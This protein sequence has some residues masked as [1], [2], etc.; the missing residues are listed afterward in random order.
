MKFYKTI[1]YFAFITILAISSCKKDFWGRTYVK[2]NNSIISQNSFKYRVNHLELE[3]SSSVFDK[4][5][6][7]EGKKVIGET[8]VILVHIDVCNLDEKTL[9]YMKTELELEKSE[10]KDC[11][12]RFTIPY[13]DI[14]Y[15]NSKE[16]FFEA[17]HC[18]ETFKLCLK[19]NVKSRSFEMALTFEN[20]L[21]V[22]PENPTKRKEFEIPVD[23]F[24]NFNLNVNSVKFQMIKDVISNH[25]ELQKH[26]NIILESRCFF[27]KDCQK[28]FSEGGINNRPAELFQNLGKRLKIELQREAY[29][30]QNP[31]VVN[32]YRV[33]KHA[34]PNKPFGKSTRIP[35]IDSLKLGQFAEKGSPLEFDK[36]KS[37]RKLPS[38]DSLTLEH[39]TLKRSKDSYQEYDKEKS[40]HRLPSVD[41]LTS[42]IYE[43]IANSTDRLKATSKESIPLG[44]E[45][46]IHKETPRSK[47]SKNHKKRNSAISPKAKQDNNNKNN[48]KKHTRRASADTE[49]IKRKFDISPRGNNVPYT[50]LSKNKAPS[51]VN[52]SLIRVEEKSAARGSSDLSTFYELAKASGSISYIPDIT[53]NDDIIF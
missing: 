32:R 2:V 41:L 17:D 44:I 23:F 49:L 5:K 34:I 7:I 15:C 10:D 30:R 13:A 37:N 3:L 47:H 38:V 43:L 25:P 39:L 8:K 6:K 51:S 45:K 24:Y 16:T 36:E 40:S 19:F 4:D 9:D 11:I 21:K 22:D 18:R 42:G 26:Q 48:N 35:S 33:L 12:Y 28:N 52:L 1:I 53:G 46:S 50:I 29:L 20:R 27:F 14:F 31:V